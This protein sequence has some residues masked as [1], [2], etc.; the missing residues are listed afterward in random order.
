MASRFYHQ[1]GFST[2]TGHQ[3]QEEQANYKKDS[4]PTVAARPRNCLS[5][6]FGQEKGRSKRIEN[7]TYIIIEKARKFAGGERV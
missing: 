4:Y 3:G 1:N 6:A 7:S 2:Y 5:G